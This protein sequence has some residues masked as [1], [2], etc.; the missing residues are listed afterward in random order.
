MTNT[1]NSKFYIEKSHAIK[2]YFLV[3]NHINSVDNL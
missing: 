3:G 1:Y 2:K